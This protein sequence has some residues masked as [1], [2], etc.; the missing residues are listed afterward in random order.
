MDEKIL[1]KG[2]KIFAEHETY[3][4]G[5]VKIEQNKITEVGHVDTLNADSVR[6][7]KEIQLSEQHSMLPGFIDVHIH[8]AGGADVMDATADALNVMTKTLPKEGTTSFLATTMTQSHE[9]IKHALTN[10]S[11]YE[12]NGYNKPGQAEV[13]GIHL[14]GPFISPNRA[15]A[16]P[17]EYID[18]PNVEVFK[19]W[20]TKASDLIKLVTL[21]PEEDPDLQLTKHLKETGVI[22]S[23]GHSDATFEQVED[24]IHA[25]VSHATHLFNQMRGLHHREPGVVGAAYLKDDLMT[26]L[27]VDGVHV[28]PE[29]VNLSYQQIGKDRLVLITDAIRAKCL[30]SGVYDLGGQSVT[31]KDDKA[32]LTDG[33]LAGSVLKMNR[34]IQNMLSFTDTN[35]EELM[36]MAS[37]NPA[38]ELKLFDRKGSI[39]EGKDADL[40]ILDENYD[41]ALTICRGLVAFQ[42]EEVL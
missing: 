23:I 38:K 36:Q 6:D 34:S 14:E 20:Q 11:Y 39:T 29:M 4:R 22:A 21:A 3:E 2:M 1:L 30:K 31:V 25:G 32:T 7:Y 19:E 33:T 41:V 15:G 5:Y 18:T 40:V 35:L 12:E 10:V 37:V 16:Q 13:V 27:I 24:A 8:G 17:S 9:A 42:R 28:A 26:E